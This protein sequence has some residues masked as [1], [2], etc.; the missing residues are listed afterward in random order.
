MLSP[1]RRTVFGERA[2]RVH[3]HT[4]LLRTPRD[5]EGQR[6]GAEKVPTSA[7]QRAATSTS[8]IADSVTCAR[9]L[10]ANRAAAT[11]PGLR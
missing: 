9:P 8:A 10:Y 5:Q 4:P 11:A 2:E 1:A 3:A 6:R 7:D